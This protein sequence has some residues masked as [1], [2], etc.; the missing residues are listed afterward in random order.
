MRSNKS[1]M[2]LS[3]I[4]PL[5]YIKGP[6]LLRPFAQSENPLTAGQRTQQTSTTKVSK[7]GTKAT[8]LLVTMHPSAM[9]HALVVLSCASDAYSQSCYK[10]R[11]SCSVRN[12]RRT[13]LLPEGSRKLQAQRLQRLS[14]PQ[15]PKPLKIH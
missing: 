4:R 5:K 3:Y 13:W 12:L 1:S 6:T 2:F 11:N 9:R 8:C 10:L 7:D 15:V 14:L